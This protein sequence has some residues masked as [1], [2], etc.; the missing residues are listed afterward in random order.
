M[1][2][3]TDKS[4][5]LSQLHFS[6]AGETQHLT[7][8][9]VVPTA[10]PRWDKQSIWILGRVACV[11]VCVCAAKNTWHIHVLCAGKLRGAGKLFQAQGFYFGG[12]LCYCFALLSPLLYLVSSLWLCS[13][14]IKC[15]SESALDDK[16]E[17]NGTDWP[18]LIKGSDSLQLCFQIVWLFCS[19]TEK[20]L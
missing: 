14:R 1:K 13:H 3:E 7:W 4:L 2:N 5:N 18:A 15:L 20:S 6:T 19:S 11:G 12:L 10:T 8:Q 9:H 16:L 17:K